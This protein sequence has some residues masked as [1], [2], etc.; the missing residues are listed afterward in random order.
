LLVAHV[1]PERADAPPEVGRL[2]DALGAAL[3]AHMIPRRIA[4]IAALPTTAGG[5]LDRRALPT[6]DGPVRAG[7]AIDPPEGAAERRVA[8]AFA[9]AL[10]LSGADA[11]ATIDRHADFFGALGGTS[12]TAVAAVLALR[13]GPASEEPLGE[14]S[15]RDVNAAPSVAALAA[16]LRARGAEPFAG[17]TTFA[18]TTTVARAA[19]VTA[20]NILSEFSPRASHRAWSRASPRASQRASRPGLFTALQLIWLAAEVWVA[21]AAA[22]GVVFVA[23]SWWFRWLGP[24][25]G[26]IALP[27]FGA[28]IRVA[29]LPVSIAWAAVVKRAVIGRYAPGRHPLWGAFHLRYWLASRAARAIPWALI[30]STEWSAV[31]LRVLGARVG[32]RVHV[33]RGVD[34]SGAAWDL[35]SLDDDVTLNQDSAVQTVEFEAGAIVVDAVSLGAGA[36]LE[37]RAGV[38]PG[39]SIGRGGRLTALSRLGDGAAVPAGEVWDGVPARAAGRNADLPVAAG[40]ALDP[41]V[42]AVL[43]VALRVLGPAVAALPAFALAAALLRV[44]RIDGTV[45]QSWLR[46]PSMSVG[47]AAAGAA[48]LAVLSAF[49]LAAGLAVEA[50]MMRCA[51]RVRPG[52]IDRRS[53]AHLRLQWKTGLVTTAGTWLSG[54]MLWPIWLRSA[55]MRVGRNAEVSTIIDTVPELVAIGAGSFLADGVFLAGPRIDRGAVVIAETALGEDTFVGNHAVIPAGAR[56]PD[57]LFVGVATVADASIATPGSAW[58]GHPPFALPRRAVVHADRRLTHAP[59]ALRW[60]TRAFWESLRLALPA[61]PVAVL[62]GWATVI[63]AAAARFGALAAIAWAAPVATVAAAVVL[64][65]S[66]V[67]LKWALL[68][69]VKP[70]QH[71]FWSCWCG[72]WDF[73]YMAWGIWTGGVLG[74]LSGTLLLNA[75][76]RLFGARIGRRVALGPGFGQVVD[77]DMLTFGDDAVVFGQFQA[78]TFED[79]I[80][81]IGP[82]DIGPGAAVGENAVLFYGAQI[83]AGARVGP[84]SVVMK[85][86]A[87][88]ANRSYEGCPT[89]L[90]AP[91]ASITGS[92]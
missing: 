50:A 86:D 46:A 56:Y 9:A 10:G 55:G 92:P 84:H 4:W 63:A 68:G 17:A 60:A 40:R 12:L 83:G 54:S 41:R 19:G 53:L 29:W 75:V 82:V 45:I 7:P 24:T 25:A 89:R 21:G 35:L 13:D 65:G 61:W 30:A 23:G 34:L 87:L 44:V 85:G 32:P 6:I 80:L 48:A 52:V 20:P 1:V 37:V 49:G 42:H 51:G 28:A 62:A 47:H 18:G 73:L 3:P 31:A 33:H 81:K 5:K 11:A 58:F 8:S 74:R 26:V 71:A 38:G 69:R 88:Q 90:A 77:P 76:L 70:G 79:R 91:G 64:I 15:V 59:D 78:H 2:V 27:L 57:G 16:R 36:T 72:R 14:V 39:G 67:A 66:V 43:A 22:L